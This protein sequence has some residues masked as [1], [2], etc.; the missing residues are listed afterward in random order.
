MTVQIRQHPTPLVG[1]VWGSLPDSASASTPPPPRL[2][3]WSEGSGRTNLGSTPTSGVGANKTTVFLLVTNLCSAP[4][5]G[6]GAIR[7]IDFAP[8]KLERRLR[9]GFIELGG[10]IVQ[11]AFGGR[12]VPGQTTT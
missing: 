7:P 9:P 5:S 3:G 11:E 12:L 6:A 10:G 4:T 2:S 8:Q 1:V